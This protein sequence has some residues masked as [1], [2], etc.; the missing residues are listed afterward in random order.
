MQLFHNPEY[1]TK[2]VKVIKDC[3]P[4]KTNNFEVDWYGKFIRR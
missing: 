3:Y 2:A 4:I 1:A